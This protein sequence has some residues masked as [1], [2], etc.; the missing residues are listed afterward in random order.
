MMVI[1]NS[2]KCDQAFLLTF[3]FSTFGP[4][5]SAFGTLGEGWPEPAEAW[6]DDPL[7]A[8]PGDLFAAL[9][10]L[11]FGTA[12]F[13]PELRLPLACWLDD[14]SVDADVIFDVD[15]VEAADEIC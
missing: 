13:Y 11:G 14:L 1:Y 4:L 5:G 9:L 10:P 7:P 15:V 6:P 2:Y 8:D 3:F 12:R